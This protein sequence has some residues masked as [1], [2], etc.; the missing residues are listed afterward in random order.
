MSGVKYKLSAFVLLLLLVQFAANGMHKVSEIPLKPPTD[1]VSLQPESPLPV[2]DACTDWVKEYQQLTPDKLDQGRLVPIYKHIA[3]L[4]TGLENY[5]YAIAFLEKAYSIAE[6]QGDVEALFQL[7][8]EMVLVDIK[9]GDLERAF[10]DLKYAQ[11]HEVKHQSEYRNMLLSEAYG[12]YYKAR[13]LYRLSIDYFQTALTSAHELDERQRISVLHLYYSESLR[14]AGLTALANAHIDSALLLVPQSLFNGELRS[15]SITRAEI[16]SVM[17]D[18]E[19]AKEALL[20]AYDIAKSAQNP[21]LEASLGLS[22]SQ[23]LVD[24]QEYEAAYQYRLR[25]FDLRDSLNYLISLTSFRLYDRKMMEER[26]Q[27][28]LEQRS[29]RSVLFQ[30][31]SWYT[32]LFL[33]VTIAF[34]GMFVLMSYR[35]YTRLREQDRDLQQQRSQN[36]SQNSKL[37]LN[38]AHAE[39]LRKEN[40]HR[41]EQQ[42]TARQSLFYKNSL[43]MNSIEYANTIQLSLRPNQ[44]NLSSRF[45]NHCIIY[46]PNHIVSGD[47]LWFADLPQRSIFILVDCSGHEVAGAALSF[48]AYMQLNQ[49][50]REENITT[51]TRIIEAFAQHFYDL[52][53]DSTENFQMLSNVKMGVLIIDH[54]EHKA[55]FSGA[56]QSLFY[57]TDGRTIERC[58]GAMHTVSLDT[59]FTIKE[60][61]LTVELTQ[62]TSFYMMTDGFVEQ[63]NKDGIKIG[64]KKAAQLLSQIV[65]LPMSEQ[66]R[67]ILA[68]HARHRLGMPQVDDMTLLGVS[69]DNSFN[70]I[71]GEQ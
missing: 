6:K 51:P 13:G 17:G 44:K 42:E 59:P 26:A 33:F 69:L 36:V 43:I 46:R 32:E 11:L 39:N 21:W 56:S 23:I 66:R 64:S 58:V 65:N 57:T 48:I 45:P 47:L 27:L 40:Q 14:S 68:Y 49:I 18:K 71:S 53:E 31:R 62:K 16:Y 41:K 38:F 50:V 63:L 25:S 4:L 35:S 7:R 30:N 28:E 61:V 5:A 9:K 20:E 15:C 1:S 60:D 52:W 22:L 3:Q 55:Y 19:K 29:L 70:N 67:R 2:D 54:A 10:E 12:L 34:G 37:I 24:E 8:F